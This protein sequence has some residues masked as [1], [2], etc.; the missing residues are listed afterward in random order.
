LEKA[1][2]HDIDFCLAYFGIF[3]SRNGASIDGVVSMESLLQDTLSGWKEAGVEKTAKFLFMVRLFMPSI[4]G[5]TTKDLVAHAQ[6]LAD[7]GDL[8]LSTYFVNASLVD[9]SVMHVQFM[10]AVY[11]VITAQLPVVAEDALTLGA[12]HFILKFGR[13]STTSH[14]LGFL[15]NRI[16]EFIPTK[17]LKQAGST[18]QDW[19][20]KLLQRVESLS[21]KAVH[22]SSTSIVAFGGD[23]GDDNSQSSD[24]ATGSGSIDRDLEFVEGK[25]RLS[26][27]RK[28]ME[29]IYAMPLY[30]L[31]LFKCTQRSTRSLPDTVYLG[32]HAEGIRVLDKSKKVL[33]DF[34][35]EELF[36]WVS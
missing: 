15:G 16:V 1:G 26:P 29:M 3:E 34:H 24:P 28:Y 6:G 12:L 21:A 36:R 7:Q 22:V 25:R 2:V 31:T 19:E 5:L 8:P 14:K 35:I 10:Q 30:G 32:L 4:S 13:F 23:N 20:Q 18:M 11:H 17:L 9:E 27:L 33:R